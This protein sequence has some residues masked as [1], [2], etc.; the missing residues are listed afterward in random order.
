MTNSYIQWCKLLDFWKRESERER[1]REREKEREREER[2]K[3]NES[4]NYLN[5]FVSPYKQWSCEFS[6]FKNTL[7]PPVLKT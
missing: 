3:W 5:L 4:V 1:E 6:Y 7:L 2:E